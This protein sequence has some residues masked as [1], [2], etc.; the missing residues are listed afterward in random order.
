[1]RRL[2]CKRQFLA[3]LFGQLAEASSL[4]EIEAGLNSHA[5]RL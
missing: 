5:A 3:L 1:V 2:N 4:G